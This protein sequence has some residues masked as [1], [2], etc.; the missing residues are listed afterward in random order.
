MINCIIDFAI[1]GVIAIVVSGGLYLFNKWVSKDMWYD[2][3]HDCWWM[4]EDKK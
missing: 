2:G 4:K 1:G 3:E